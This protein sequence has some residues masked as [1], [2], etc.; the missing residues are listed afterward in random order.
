MI[1]KKIKFLSKND[2][3]KCISMKAAIQSMEKA[4]SELT[5]GHIKVPQRFSMDL[6]HHNG[7]SLFMPVY[8][9]SENLVGLKTVM[10]HKGNPIKNL[11]MIHATYML[12]N[13]DTGEVL[14]FMDAEYI[15]ALRTGAA[16]GLA[17]RYLSKNESEVLVIFGAG[18]QART[19]LEAVH[20]VRT[21]SKV[22][23]VDLNYKKAV[24]FSEQ[25][26]ET[27]NIEVFPS[28]NREIIKEA[29]IICT[30]TSSNSPVFS[31]EDLQDGTHI[32]GIGSYRRDMCEIPGATI[33]RAKLVV[34]SKEA[35]M[36]EAGD[37]LQAIENKRITADHIHAE[38]GELVDSTKAARVIDSEITIFK[39][40]GVAAQD[41]VVAALV[42]DYSK[43][44][45]VGV[46]LEIN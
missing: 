20:E 3:K 22:Y 2:I 14:A 45:D 10:L 43:K 17:T 7:G 1:S 9:P 6:E 46:D 21:I 24:E 33:Q 13:A 8:M 5:K 19:Q 44:M 25:M 11:P 41:I 28:P 38:L 42:Y 36:K 29:H 31:D 34:D 18:I 30:A 12:F 40:V 27:M 15:T 32:N 4:F 16:S 35:A 23:I 39:S 37:I 26:S